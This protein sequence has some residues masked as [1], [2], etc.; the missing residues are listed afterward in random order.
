MVTKPSYLSARHGEECNDEAIFRRAR[1]CLVCSSTHVG[2]M[3]TSRLL[4]PLRVLVM[5]RGSN[6]NTYKEKMRCKPG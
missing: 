5:T 4:R 6:G 2:P 1:D 3:G